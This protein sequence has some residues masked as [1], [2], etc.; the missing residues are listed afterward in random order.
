MRSTPPKSPWIE[1]FTGKSLTAPAQ[2]LW[3]VEQDDGEF[4]SITGATVTSRAVVTA[5]KNTL[6]YFEQHHTERYAAAAA[7]PTPMS[8]LSSSLREATLGLYATTHRSCNC[9]GCAPARR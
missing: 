8:N 9:S 3:D 5:V 1:Q 4:D 6:L 2:A 7:A